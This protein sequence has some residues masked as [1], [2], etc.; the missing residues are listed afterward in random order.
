M[1]LRSSRLRKNYGG[2]LGPRWSACVGPQKNNPAGCSKRP[3]TRPQASPNRRRTLGGTLRIST[4]R[5]R[6][7]R[8]FSASCQS[9]ELRGML[10][11]MARLDRDGQ[12]SPAQLATSKAAMRRIRHYR[13]DGILRLHR[14][15][16]TDQ[17]AMLNDNC[18]MF[19]EHCGTSIQLS[20]LK[21]EHQVSAG[22][23]SSSIFQ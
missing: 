16:C 3:P 19:S 22:S 6:R 13:E 23:A 14:E 2:T 15:G 18:L 12:A 20:T 1:R 10:D 7:R 17:E 8:D 4:S 9:S 11:V 21:I 5:E